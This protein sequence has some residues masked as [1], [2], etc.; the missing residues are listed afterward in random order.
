MFPL[1]LGAALAASPD[2]AVGYHGHTLT[3]P[4]ATVRLS[5]SLAE[6]RAGDLRAEA[7]ADLWWHPRNQV[8]LGVHAGPAWVWTTKRDREVGL[9]THVGVQRSTWAAPTWRVDEQGV[10]RVPLAGRT[11]GVLSIGLHSARPLLQGP[12]AWFFRP[13][14][15]LRFPDLYGPGVDVAFQAGVRFGGAA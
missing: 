3:H 5:G 7:E 1:L 2:L 12:E 10:S 14:V 6:G 15:S 9:L 4:G 13:R 11:Q 8:A